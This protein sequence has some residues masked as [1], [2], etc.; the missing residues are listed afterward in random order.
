MKRS[1]SFYLLA[2]IVLLLAACDKPQIYDSQGR[3]YDFHKHAD[4]WIVLNYWASWCKPCYE[5]IPELNRLALEH[6][7]KLVVFGVNFDR[8][9]VQELQA[10][11]QQQQVAYPLLVT[12]P[13]HLFGINDIPNLPATFLI[14]PNNQQI[15]ALYGPQRAVDILEK[16]RTGS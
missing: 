6:G 16:I 5:E 3:G 1:F 14:S 7:D 9:G 12:N 15:I 2:V 11:A 4:K 8:I 10:F 13:A